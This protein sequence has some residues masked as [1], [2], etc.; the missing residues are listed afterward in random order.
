MEKGPTLAQKENRMKDVLCFRKM[1]TPI[2]IQFLFWVA[3]AVCV[4]VFA[5]HC[6]AGKYWVALQVIILGPL[7]VRVA[8]EVTLVLFRIYDMLVQINQKGSF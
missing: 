3:I 2:I 7:V 5:M 4:V 1:I 6:V 8:A